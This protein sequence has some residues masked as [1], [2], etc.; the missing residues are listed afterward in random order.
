MQKGVRKRELRKLLIWGNCFSK[1]CVTTKGCVASCVSVPSEFHDLFF[2]HLWHQRL[3]LQFT[4]SAEPFPLILSHDFL[5]EK[6][7]VRCQQGV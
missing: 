2:R 1:A 3:R 4:C 7:C 5:A 6:L